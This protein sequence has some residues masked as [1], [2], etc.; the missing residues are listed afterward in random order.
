MNEIVS[1]RGGVPS[2]REDFRPKA[3]GVTTNQFRQWTKLWSTPSTDRLRDKFRGSADCS[4]EK[5]RLQLA[6]PMGQFAVTISRRTFPRI[7]PLMNPF[8]DKPFWVVGLGSFLRLQVTATRPD[9][10]LLNDIG[11]GA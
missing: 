1:N 9:C 7:H 4:P 5:I 2:P 6:G 11:G 3:V 8:V 10:S